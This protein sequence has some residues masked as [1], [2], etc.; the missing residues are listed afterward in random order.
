MFRKIQIMI[1]QDNYTKANESGKKTQKETMGFKDI[2]LPQS[3][4]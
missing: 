1:K 2:A 4:N 3:K